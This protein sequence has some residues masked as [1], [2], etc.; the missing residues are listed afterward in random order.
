MKLNGYTVR[1]GQLILGW[2]RTAQ[3]AFDL[4]DT[5]GGRHVQVLF[6]Q[7]TLDE[8]QAIE[9]QEQTRINSPIGLDLQESG[10]FLKEAVYSH[11]AK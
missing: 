6:G 3:K 11:E 9:R 4:A 2:R 10:A 8:I 7:H 5:Y 1:S